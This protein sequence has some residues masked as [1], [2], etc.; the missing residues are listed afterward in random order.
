MYWLGQ[1]SLTL[2]TCLYFVWFV[3]QLI[4]TF[5]RKDTSGLSLWMHSILFLGYLTDLMYG[6]GQHLPI[7]YRLVTIAGLIS[8]AI[9]HYQFGYYGLMSSGERNNYRAISLALLIIFISVLYNITLRVDSASVY[10]IVGIISMFCW[11]VFAMPQ[12]IK[13]YQNQST[14]GLSF[15]FVVLS[16]VT[17]ILDL[18]STYALNWPWASKVGAPLGL[19]Q[20]IILLIQCY[21]YQKQNKQL[22]VEVA[23]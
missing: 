5:K 19:I 17:G 2:S 4:L 11:L 21:G 13:N 22:I 18:I 10:N 16:V 15:S 6:F 3:P 20:K 23:I 9:E 7:Q 8:L 12:I 1:L 14:E